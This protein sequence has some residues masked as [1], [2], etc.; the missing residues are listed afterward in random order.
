MQQG[1]FLTLRM[2]GRGVDL[3]RL[4]RLRRSLER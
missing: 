3:R 2:R 4:R 1:C